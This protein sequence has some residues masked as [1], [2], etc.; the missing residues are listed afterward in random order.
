MENLTNLRELRENYMMASFDEKDANPNP[1]TQ[2]NKWFTQALSAEV[3]EPNAFSLA[4]IDLHGNP[5]IR[6]VLLKELDYGFVFFTNYDSAKGI[7]LNQTPSAAISFL[8][9]E[10]E[11]QVRI[12]GRVEKISSQE[13]DDYFYSRPFESQLGAIASQQSK[14]LNDRSILEIEFARLKNENRESI[15]RP[16]NWGGYRII[17]SYFEFWQGRHS[18]LHDRITYKQTSEN[19]WERIRLYP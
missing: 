5:N 16:E 18:R 10:L 14:V 13:S 19:E 3:P 6:T 17:P 15:R 4:T 8:W 2:F 9:L 12:K 7:E 1:L 11:R